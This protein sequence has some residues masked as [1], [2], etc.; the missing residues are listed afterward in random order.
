MMTF[1][2]HGLNL[3]DILTWKLNVIKRQKK[4]T[5]N[6][7]IFYEANAGNKPFNYGVK[8]MEIFFDLEVLH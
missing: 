7:R 1:T 6:S 5:L 8:T 2:K 3:I 4:T